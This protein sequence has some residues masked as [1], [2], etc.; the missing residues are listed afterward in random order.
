MS[1]ANILVTIIFLPIFACVCLRV[2]SAE[3]E[4]NII[5]IKKF[6]LF[7]IVATFAL[8]IFLWCNFDSSTHDYQFSYNFINRNFINFHLSLDGISLFF[9]CLTTFIIPVALLRN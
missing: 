8:R 9:V 2:I 4:T 5:K 7:T 3:T 1:C 6:S